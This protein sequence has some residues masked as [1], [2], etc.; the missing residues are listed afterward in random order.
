MQNNLKFDP[1]PTPYRH[2][3]SIAPPPIIFMDSKPNHIAF[4]QLQETGTYINEHR[5]I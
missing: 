3:L 5:N 4:G 1:T 2:T